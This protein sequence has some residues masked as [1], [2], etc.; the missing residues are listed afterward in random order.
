MKR[1]R[2]TPK[3][4]VQSLEVQRGRRAQKLT[5]SQLKHVKYVGSRT[6]AEAQD[7]RCILGGCQ[8]YSPFLDPYYN[9]AP[10]I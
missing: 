5:G 2:L 10:N 1:G 4:S 7:R 6:R 9:T 3:R 8:N